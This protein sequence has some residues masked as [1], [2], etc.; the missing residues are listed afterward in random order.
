M[1]SS[2]SAADWARRI[3]SGPHLLEVRHVGGSHRLGT[4]VIRRLDVDKSYVDPTAGVD[5]ALSVRDPLRAA[6]FAV[7]RPTLGRHRGL[8]RC[9]TSQVWG[10]ACRMPTIR[11]RHFVTETDDLA[12]ALDAATVRWPD[13]SRAQ[14]LVRLALE[15]HRFAQ[16]AHDDR[17][18]RRLAALPKH[19]GALAGVYGQEHLDRLR[20]EWPA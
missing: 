3:R 14:V 4:L 19:S 11:P 18:R 12:P 13:L 20:E 6:A 17:R 2:A 8:A 15:G 1:V 7:L 16:Q 10:H 5:R 9:S